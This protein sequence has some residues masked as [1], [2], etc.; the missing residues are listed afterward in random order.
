M[1]KC[2]NCGY[3]LKLTDWRPECP[4]CGVNLLY[5]NMEERLREDADK[6][7]LELAKSQPVYDRMKAAIYGSPYAIIRLV[8]LVLPLAALML[9][10][11]KISVA[12]P[13]YEKATTINAVAVYNA[14]SSL[15]FNVLFKL[16][17]SEIYGKG[18]ILF[19]AAMVFLLLTVVTIL[20]EF[21]CVICA[22]GKKWFPRNIILGSIG[23]LF[24]V[25][26][27]VFF[28]LSCSSLQSAL[29]D[30]FTGSVGIFGVIAVV[31]TF[32]LV[33]GINVLIKVKN[34]QVKYTDVS[35]YYLPY[36]ERPSVIAAK[37]AEQEAIE[38]AKRET[39]ENEMKESVS[40]NT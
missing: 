1:A 17:G 7:E 6:A 32:G 18:V 23:I 26:S 14:I 15:D 4:K 24:T 8:L 11:G 29:P 38:K 12:L 10:L 21:V 34:I 28:S 31:L 16:A 5:F 19:I 2:G 30:I 3:K 20:L 13:F 39:E 9:P 22:F 27:A 37:K 36:H 40:A 35:E 25:L 33:I